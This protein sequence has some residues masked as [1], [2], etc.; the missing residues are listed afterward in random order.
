[1]TCATHKSHQRL[2]TNR[3]KKFL[4]ALAHVL[5]YYFFGWNHGVTQQQLRYCICLPNVYILKWMCDVCLDV[6]RRGCDWENQVGD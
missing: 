5:H 1:M 2:L 3:F 4:R 6:R